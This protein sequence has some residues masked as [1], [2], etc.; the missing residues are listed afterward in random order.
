M[1]T[2]LWKP[3]VGAVFL[4]TA[5]ACSRVDVTSQLQQ[6]KQLADAG[7]ADAAARAYA[8]ALRTDPSSARAHLELGA[9][10]DQKLGDPIGAIYHYRVYLELEPNSEKRQVVQDFIEHAKLSLAAK[11]SQPASSDAGAVPGLQA[12]RAALMQEN[13]TLK[14]RVTDLE[15]A[16]AQPVAVAVAPPVAAPPAL[17]LAAAPITGA[18]EATTTAGAGRVHVVQAGDTLQALALRY[19]G[20]RGEWAKIFDAN[21]TLLES[22]DRLKIGQQLV[23]P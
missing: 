1:V 7:R 2:S 21:R 15:N 10:L 23:I 19:Y 16:A 5:V 8:D 3:L 20:T 22:K 18:T 6:G 14:A 11:L 12:E 17:V 9:L 4:A 13:A